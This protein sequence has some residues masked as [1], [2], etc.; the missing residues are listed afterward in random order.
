MTPF[1]PLDWLRAFEAAARHASFTAAAAEIGLTQAAVSQHIRKLEEH[2]GAPLFRRLP[3]GVELTADG[4]AYLPHVQAAFAVLA[5]STQDMFQRGRR[6]PVKLVCPPS[7]AGLWL[8]PRLAALIEAHPGLRVNVAVVAKPADYEAEAGDLEVRFGAGE[9]EGH[10]SAALLPEALAPVASPSL[11]ARLKDWSD[12][13]LIAVTGPRDGWSQWASVAGM[14]LKGP[15]V[16]RFDTLLIALQAA[17]AGAGVLL[18]SL[19]L[20]EGVLAD[21]TLVQIHPHVLRTGTGHFLARDRAKRRSA[22]AETVWRWLLEA[23]RA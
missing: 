5:R 12:R 8:A 13:P 22:D 14:N 17:R 23:G 6:A 16:A 21:G 15:V 1:P 2:L 18:A 11:T 3:R 19:P 9:W 4:A 7:F 10:E 20:A